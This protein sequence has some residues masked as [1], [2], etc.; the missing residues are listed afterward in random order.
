MKDKYGVDLFLLDRKSGHLYVP[1]QNGI[2]SIIEEKGWIYPTESMM[3]D[4]VAGN[5]HL[6]ITMAEY[7]RRS[8]LQRQRINYALSEKGKKPRPPKIPVTP[9]QSPKS[10]KKVTPEPDYLHLVPIRREHQTPEP[11]RD[12]PSRR[13]EPIPIS[14]GMPIENKLL[15][16]ILCQM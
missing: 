7:E 6:T 15:L 11:S 1:N 12:S 8:K 3:I 5:K 10:K 2:Y 16:G 13:K 9:P 14:L 4:P